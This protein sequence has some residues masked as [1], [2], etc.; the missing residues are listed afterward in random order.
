MKKKVKNGIEKHYC[1]TC[2]KLLY[3]LVPDKSK[4]TSKTRCKLGTI[5]I[6]YCN[7]KRY[8]KSHS[9]PQGRE[10]CDECYAERNRR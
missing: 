3:D 10:Y 9:A 5:T 8:C 2:G 4:P 1:D 6:S 7:T